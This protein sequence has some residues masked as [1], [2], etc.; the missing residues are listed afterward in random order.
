MDSEI[1]SINKRKQLILDCLDEHDFK[2]ALEHTTV[3][4]SLT[5]SLI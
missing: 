2:A 3:F 4:K 1:E 5:N